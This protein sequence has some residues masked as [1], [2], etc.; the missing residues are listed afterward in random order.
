MAGWIVVLGMVGM[1]LFTERHP[2][3]HFAD[4]PPD[5]SVIKDLEPGLQ[6]AMRANVLIERG[7]GP[8]GLGARAIGSGVILKI[9]AGEALI[10]TNR[11]VVD[12]DF[13][14]SGPATDDALHLARLGGCKVKMLGPDRGHPPW[15]PV[16][17]VLERLRF[18]KR[19]VRHPPYTARSSR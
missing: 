16:S 15:A 3:L 1:W 12:D 9:N 6:R 10:V 7:V 2:D 18:Q 11:H 17:S 14:S 4:R 5:M 8:A 19:R 13:P